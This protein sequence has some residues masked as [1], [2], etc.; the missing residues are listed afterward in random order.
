MNN[1]IFEKMD[2][3]LA[4]HFRKPPEDDSRLK[5]LESDVWARIVARKHDEPIGVLE[6]FLAFLFPAQHRLAPVM[7]AAVLGVVV[8]FGTLPYHS[9][10]PDAAEMLNFKVFK[11]QIISLASITPINERL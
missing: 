3:L 1:S 6:G 2:L 9:A 5:H 10:S 4:H 8:G 11:P 7:C